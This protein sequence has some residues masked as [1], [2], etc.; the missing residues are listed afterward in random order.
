[1]DESQRIVIT[2]M[3]SVAPNAIGV[4]PFWKALVA[5]KSGIKPVSLFD[6]GSLGRTLGG[7][8]QD[9]DPGAWLGPDQ[10]VPAGRLQQF[11]LVA[12]RMA[13][14]DA[15]IDRPPPGGGLL[16]GTALGTQHAREQPGALEDPRITAPLFREPLLPELARALGM[17]DAS[18][19]LI[20]N[21][22]TSGN[23]VTALAVQRLRRGQI[24][25]AVVGGAETLNLIG[26]A[27]FVR[28]GAMA[29]DACRPFDKNRRGLMYSEGAASLVLETL[30][31]ARRRGARIHAELAGHGLSC[32]ASHITAPHGRG[33]A[34]AMNAALRSAGLG[35]EQVDYVGAHGTGTPANDSSE[36]RAILSVLGDRGRKVPVSS[37]KSMIGHTHGAAN[38]HHAI[39][40][41]LAIR[42]GV[43]PPTINHETPD[44][45]CEVDCV[46]NTAREV[47]VD[48]ALINGAGFG[49]NNGC[50]A[51]RRFA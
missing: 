48:V 17:E 51:L 41:V 32:D 29:P 36:S 1:V 27:S 23:V 45:E 34:L 4:E 11:A 14:A 7:E 22:C 43:V 21:A 20:T 15:G 50:L 46:P 8:V 5:G 35:P 28:L 26:F 12:A 25:F 13:L 39:A 30:A 9:F 31:S 42:D 38:L 47:K 6:P 24:P 40:A 2:G 33:M 18:P 3:G 10:P 19:S 44:P 37:I 16:F 49:G